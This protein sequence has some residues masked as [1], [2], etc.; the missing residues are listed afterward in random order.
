MAQADICVNGYVYKVACENGQEARLTQ[1]G[2]YFDRQVSSL[3]ADL[4]QIGESRLLLL[5]SLQLCD[6]LFETRRRLVELERASASLD[7]STVGG[8]AR[9]ISDAAERV[10]VMAQRAARG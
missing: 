8:A 10:A 1:L 5:A 2:Q 3:A 9:L 7:N 4:G 6:E